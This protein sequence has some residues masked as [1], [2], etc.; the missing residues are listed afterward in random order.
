MREEFTAKYGPPTLTIINDEIP[1]RS[2]YFWCETTPTK[3]DRCNR[4]ESFAHFGYR[5]FTL[6][7]TKY[8][9]A[10]AAE[11]KARLGK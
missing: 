8:I 7:N 5:G 4:R 6:R 9:K 2:Q 3:D 11:K 1:E 10:F